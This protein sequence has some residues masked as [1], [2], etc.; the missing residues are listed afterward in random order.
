MRDAQLAS[1]NKE[2]VSSN[3]LNHPR[4]TTGASG[5]DAPVLDIADRLIALQRKNASATRRAERPAPSPAVAATGNTTPILVAGPSTISPAPPPSSSPLGNTY[6]PRRKTQQSSRPARNVPTSVDADFDRTLGKTKAAPVAGK[7]FDPDTDPVPTRLA[8]PHLPP[9]LAVPQRHR[10]PEIMSETSSAGPSRLRNGMLPGVGVSQPSHGNA[11]PGINGLA[12]TKPNSR[13]PQLRHAQPQHTQQQGPSLLQRGAPPPGAKQLFDPSRDDPMRFSVLSRQQASLSSV[14]PNLGMTPADYASVSSTSDT[15]SFPS[16]AFT[17]SSVTSASSVDSGLSGTPKKDEPGSV[18]PFVVELKRV[19]REISAL[20][21][22]LLSEDPPVRSVEEEYDMSRVQGHSIAT[23]TADETWVRLIASHKVLAE[24]HHNLLLLTTNANVPASMQSIPDKYNIPTR[25]WS[26]SFHRLIVALR[27]ASLTSPRA[28]E[29]LTSFIYYAYH[30]YTS[31]L[32][33]RNLE[34]YRGKWLEAL[35]DLANYRLL[36]AVHAANIPPLQPAV[37]AASSERDESMV[38]LPIDP[39]V[40]KID[41]SPI[42]SVGVRAAAEWGDEDE[43]DTWRR[44]AR[45]WYAMGL[46]DTPGAGRLHHHIGML[47]QNVKGDE[48][49]TVY[50]FVK[51]LIANHP[52]DTGRDAMLE[53]FSPSMQQNLSSPT[54]PATALFLHII[55]LLFTRIDLDQVRPNLGRFIERLEL[56]EF[57][58]AEHE[59]ITMAILGVGSIFEFGRPDAKVRK[60]G[61]LA[62]GE[63][64]HPQNGQVASNASQPSSQGVGNTDPSPGA[65]ANDPISVTVSSWAEQVEE[66][67]VADATSSA[68]DAD[69]DPSHLSAPMQALST[70]PAEEDPA[71]KQ[72]QFILSLAFEVTFTILNYILSKN[73]YMPINPSF[74]QS[75]ILNPYITVILTFLSTLLKSPSV[76]QLMERYVPWQTL[77]ALFTASF[78]QISRPTPSSSR[79]AG[80]LSAGHLVPE[81]WCLRG[82]EW[83]G[84]RVYERGFWKSRCPIPSIHGEMDV[85]RPG[86]ASSDEPTTAESQDGIVEDER[87]DEM[88]WEASPAPPQA[89]SAAR[90]KRVR[91]TAEVLLKFIPGLQWDD[92]AKSVV[93]LGELEVKISKWEEERREEEREALARSRGYRNATSSPGDMEVEEE[94]DSEDVEDENDED[95]EDSEQVKDLKARRRYLRR[96]LLRSSERP[97]RPAPQK[98]QSKPPASRPALEAIPGYTVLVIDTNILLSSLSV[99]A[100]LVQSNRWTVVIPLAAV[101]ELDGLSKNNSPLGNAANDALAYLTSAVPANSSSLKVQTSKGNYLRTLSVRAENIDFH[102]DSNTDKTMDD[103]ILRS[104]SWQAEHFV[105][106]QLF[107]PG[108]QGSIMTPTS[109]T[110][111]VVLLSFDRNLRLKARS[112]RLD[113]ADEKEMGAILALNG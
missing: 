16:S 102:D 50:H 17:L 35:G 72:A 105:D 44:T 14:P 88:D 34:A 77:S 107:L 24:A 38:V 60:A 37:A 45:E 65:N 112:R 83:A 10:E 42:P 51:S 36:V 31:L 113:A 76:T 73:P 80:K 47:G 91:T 104:A 43:C 79:D 94:L 40:P 89:L 99:V 59:W 29:H 68:I 58:V 96:L 57:A 52:F 11:V 64:S 63:K 20:E 53:F 93:V 15:R 49:R 74:Q 23:E 5:K 85:I 98:R 84:R 19:Y 100:S 18:N 87:E 6:S 25:L 103:L 12:P 33:E 9:S 110:A 26:I 2:R 46:K 86:E 82:M 32:E 61:G 70:D 109:R 97:A 71:E 22:K 101:T 48:L 30:L 108:L 67:K 92:Q 95:P 8:Q 111:K 81:D 56:D 1:A 7:L 55:G 28:L 54:S 106:R 78:Q 90:W 4:A 75:P 66:D 62:G 13:S 39:P 3:V 21:K 69:Q 27:R 41:D